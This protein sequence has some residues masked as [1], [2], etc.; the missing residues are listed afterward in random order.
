VSEVP[1]A[2]VVSCSR[3]GEDCPE[4]ARFCSRCGLDLVHGDDA[5]LTQGDAPVLLPPPV[6]P[7]AAS[8]RAPAPAP[9]PYPAAQGPSP[10]AITPTAVGRRA[11]RAGWVAA[12][13]GAAVFL[14]AAG[15]VVVAAGRY[16]GVSGP[17]AQWGSMLT[18]PTRAAAD[19]PFAIEAEA[20]NPAA[21]ATD[22]VWMVIEWR[23]S[24]GSLTPAARG[25]FAGCAP[26][27][28]SYRDDPATGTTVVYWPGLPAG[29]RQA[30]T[31]TAAVTGIIAGDR[32]VY[33]VHTGTG[34]DERT[35][36]GGR[37]WDLELTGE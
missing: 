7:P 15:A 3:C 11:S 20:R 18:D 10:A 22:R 5:P 2:A 12:P 36:D 27:S 35:L 8:G 17:L 30:Y 14:V 9:T 13:G 19:V 23:P 34:P 31:V 1:N 24:D 25:R 37:T 29:G 16:P 4:G 21:T 26:S 32:L 28:C 6:P 33:R